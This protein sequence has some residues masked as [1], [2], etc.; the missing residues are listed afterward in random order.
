MNKLIDQT[1]FGFPGGNC[2][3]ACVATIFEVDLSW[4][5]YF[6]G[7]TEKEAEE[8]FA[9]FEP[10]LA[11]FSR[12]QMSHELYAIQAG[13]NGDKDEWRPQGIHILS[14]QSPRKPDD[15]NAYHSVV[16]RGHEIIFDPHPSRDGLLTIL[17]TV[18]FVTVD[19]VEAQHKLTRAHEV[20]SDLAD[21]T[22][23]LTKD[24]AT[25]PPELCEAWN[26]IA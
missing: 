18:F 4:V 21:V 8:W 25:H 16:A 14:G 13:L 24:H 15:P 26:E 7:E 11:T 17:D 10:W 12:T 9:R 20:L 19:P 2:F 6:M 1:T 22:T 23:G 3:S 5:P